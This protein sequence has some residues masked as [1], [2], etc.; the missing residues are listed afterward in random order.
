MATALKSQVGKL[1]KELRSL[2]R[3][4]QRRLPAKRG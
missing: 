4:I 2:R 3:L 1:G